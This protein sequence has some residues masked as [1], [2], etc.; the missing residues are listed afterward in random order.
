MKI[1]IAFSLA[2]SLLCTSAIA[3]VRHSMSYL[4]FGS[5]ANYID[6]VDNT[7]SSLSEVSPAYFS[8]NSDGSLQINDSGIYDF[9]AQMRARDILVVPFLAN[10]WDRSLA[11]S[12]LVNMD[13]L[14]DEIV[15]AVEKYD[16]DGI[17]IDFENLTHLHRDDFSKFIQ[18][19]DNK[20]PDDKILTVCVAANPE[21][22][23]A[24]WHGS[25][26]YK[27][28]ADSADYLMIMSYDEHYEGGSAGSI[29]SY[30]FVEKSINYALNY[31]RSEQIIVGIPFFGRIWSV[32]GTSVMGEG[33]SDSTVMSYIEKYDGKT[34][35]DP[36]TGSQYAEIEIKTSGE[37]YPIGRYRIWFEGE[38]SKKNLLSLVEKYD[39]YGAGSWSLSQESGG[40]WDYYSLWLN[41]LEFSDSEGHWAVQDIIKIAD[42]G[43]MRGKSATSFAADDIVTRA[44]AVTLICRILGLEPTESAALYFADT[45]TH[46]SRGYIA[47]AREHELVLGVGDDIFLPDYEISRADIAS[48]FSRNIGSDFF[49]DEWFSSTSAITRADLACLVNRIYY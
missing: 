18:L 21:A 26:D 32:D 41:G 49:E 23:T 28:L 40:V 47:V 11:V 12:A 37:R 15:L 48:L 24:G 19:L 27:K 42:M 38:Y 4:Y 14:S 45:A 17:N 35:T 3:T 13:S 16:L 33:L 43:L 39:L 46:W 1:F 36:Q 9:V 31:A 8:L 5:S 44:E 29:A 20:L 22:Y 30:A 10:H 34:Y 7:N 25:Y 2:V 6:L